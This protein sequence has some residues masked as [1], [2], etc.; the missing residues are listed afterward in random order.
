MLQVLNV[1]D[2]LRVLA[3]QTGASLLQK[4]QGLFFSSDG[5][6]IEFGD[7]SQLNELYDQSGDVPA[8][9]DPV[10]LALDQSQGAELGPELI[11]N[12]TFDTDL[13]GWTAS[14]ADA[15][16]TWQ[17]G[18]MR[19]QRT[20]GYSLL[21]GQDAGLESGKWYQVSATV[22]EWNSGTMGLC[23]SPS[24]GGSPTSLEQSFSA[25]TGV[26]S[27]VFLGDSS[28]PVIGFSTSVGGDFVLDNVS[29][30]ELKG[31]HVTQPVSNNRPTYGETVDGTR[32][33]EFD[34]VDDFIEIEV[35]A[36]GWSG[37]VVFGWVQG[38]YWANYDL[39]AGTWSFPNDAG[40]L[41]VPDDQLVAMVFKADGGEMSDTEK[42]DALEYVQ[43][44]GAGGV[45][46]WSGFTDVERF[47]MDQPIT[48]LQSIDLSQATDF[49][50][51]AYRSDLEEFDTSTLTSVE[52]C[53]SAWDSTQ[54]T[55]F[56]TT[57]MTNLRYCYRA[58]DSSQL[59]SFDG[60]G[61]AQMTSVDPSCFL[62]TWNRAP[63]T[64]N[65]ASVESILVNIDANGLNAPGSGTENQITIDTDGSG[66]TTAAQD[67][68]TSLKAKGWDP[69][70]DGVSQ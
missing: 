46:G 5:V 56:D 69:V 34:G 54:I 70:I 44:K 24:I 29:V 43:S 4:I 52:T 39:P 14:A 21:V 26:R 17:S 22:S 37:T 61:L 45:D 40:N 32:Y 16:I 67:A 58:W 1:L 63:G 9:G 18:A 65:Q 55:S 64:L 33:I 12:G 6:W 10:G 35:P 20:G 15:D 7:A 59:V 30:R 62:L 25:D 38:S 57:P 50:F 49:D 41:Y 19:L 23:V 3:V 66:L 28:L 60:A 11:T 27:L 8:I 36:G 13:S 48:K 42:A 51:F 47:F 68:I 2:T 53:R 31:N